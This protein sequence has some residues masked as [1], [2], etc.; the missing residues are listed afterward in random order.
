MKKTV[1]AIISFFFLLTEVSA[2]IEV[3]SSNQVGIGTT[4]PQY[5]LHVVGDAFVTGNVIGNFYL[6]SDSNFFGTTGNY[7]VVFKV[8]NILSGST[9][10]SDNTNVFFGYESLFNPGSINT[11]STAIGYKALRNAAT[12]NG[13]NTALGAYSLHSNTTGSYNTAV[14]SEALRSN[15]EGNNN[16]AYGYH[17]LYSNTTGN[18]N[19]AIGSDVLY[20]NTT[21]SD[22]MAIGGNALRSNLAGSSNIAHGYQALYSNT[23]GNDNIAVGY[24]TLY[25]NVTGSNNMAIG[26]E[27]LYANSEGSDNI[28]HGHQA[29]YSNTTGKN[30]IAI[31]SSVLYNNTTGNYN[32]AIGV[33]AGGGFR[34]TDIINN[35]TAIGYQAPITGSNQV[36]I[37]NNTITSIGGSVS[38][39]NLS[40]GRAAKNIQNNVPGLSFIN[41]LQ[42]VTYNMDL[43]AMD[44]IISGGKRSLAQMQIGETLG[45]NRIIFDT[46][47]N[48][49][50]RRS[51]QST[52]TINGENGW[53]ILFRYSYA[54]Q[55]GVQRHYISIQLLDSSNTVIETIY[56]SSAWA[57]GAANE[58]FTWQWHK[59]EIMIPLEFGKIMSMVESWPGFFAGGDWNL[60]DG[61]V[62]P[63]G[64][65]P[66]DNIQ[67][68]AREDKE[69]Q[70]QTGFVAQDV[71]TAAQGVGYDFSG[72]DVDKA[73]LYSLR[74]SEF[75]VP[76]VK[77]VQELSEQNELLREQI[78]ELKNRIETLENR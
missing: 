43:D 76:L 10:S 44:E 3:H 6:R 13:H 40:D 64:S 24:A 32:T 9:G 57:I 25:N 39:S 12:G 73:G 51:Y 34:E 5:K 52:F 35:S 29:L 7:P 68:Q 50:K 42:P 70:V 26:N 45:G 22:N 11:Y 14:G 56:S 48:L 58:Q 15:S 37:G 55:S 49:G 17:T 33:G 61:W 18:D 63:P 77:A 20:S 59:S 46:S 60:N 41:S 38:W 30:N 19:I 54:F 74:Y 72:V 28:A 53:K 21:G 47:K 1:F 66:L 8:N 67:Q 16:V 27:A 2:Q 75:V 4:T 78:D 62:A 23:M 65:Q 36:R 69:A 31:G 71:E